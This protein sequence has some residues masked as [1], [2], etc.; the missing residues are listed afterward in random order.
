MT[1]VSG[2]DTEEECNE[3]NGDGDSNSVLLVTLCVVC[4]VMAFGT[5]L[6]F[7]IQAFADI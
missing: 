6:I 5:M 3:C 7:G 2:V 4:V 1:S